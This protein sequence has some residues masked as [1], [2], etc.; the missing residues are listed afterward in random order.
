MVCWQ[1]K[2]LQCHRHHWVVL[3]VQSTH[4]WWCNTGS[5]YQMVIQVTLKATT[6][7]RCRHC[8]IMSLARSLTTRYLCWIKYRHWAKAT[9]WVTLNSLYAAMK[10]NQLDVRSLHTNWFCVVP[11]TC[12]EWCWWIHAGLIL[13]DTALNY[14]KSSLVFRYITLL[15]CIVKHYVQMCTAGKKSQTYPDWMIKIWRDDFSLLLSE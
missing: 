4:V 14:T 8:L 11:V 5:F 13:L 7:F 6:A 10:E 3:P 12:Y 9:V 15:N 1:I 2:V